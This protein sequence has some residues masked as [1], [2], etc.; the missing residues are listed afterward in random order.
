MTFIAMDFTFRIFAKPLIALVPL[1][2]ILLSYFSKYRF[3]LALPGGLVAI[4]IGS[5]LAWGSGEMSG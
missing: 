5:G 2:L 1:A 3:P 4:L